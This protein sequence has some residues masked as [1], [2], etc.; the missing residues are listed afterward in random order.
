MV[1]I[2]NLRTYDDSGNRAEIRMLPKGSK[3]YFN[4]EIHVPVRPSPVASGQWPVASGQWPV[5]AKRAFSLCR[6]ESTLL[7]LSKRVHPSLQKESTLLSLSK[8][9]H[10]RRSISIKK[11][12]QKEGRGVKD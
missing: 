2:K 9:V 4:R 11:I 5:G 12:Y 10:R 1:L 8:R 3:P 6:K 7:S